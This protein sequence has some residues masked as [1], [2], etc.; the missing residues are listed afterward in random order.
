MEFEALVSAETKVY[1]TGKTNLEKHLKAKLAIHFGPRPGQ[2]SLLK[3]RDFELERLDS[4]LDAA[5]I[6]IPRLKQRGD[7]RSAFKRRPLI[8]SLG[9]LFE[10]HTKNLREQFGAEFDDPGDIPMF[11]ST[12]LN[13]KPEALKW[14]QSAGQVGLSIKNVLE[15]LTVYSERTGR[16]LHITETRIRRT[17]GTR[18][19][20]AG[21]GVLIIAEGLDH[22]GLGH[23]GVYAESRADIVQRIDA[24]TAA[25]L[26]PLAKAFLGTVIDTEKQSTNGVDPTSRIG[27]P[28]Y[29]GV[30]GSCKSRGGCR[31]NS[32]IACYRCESFEAWRDGPHPEV[33]KFLIEY[34][35]DLLRRGCE[36]LAQNLQL[37]IVACADLIRRIEG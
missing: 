9:A 11:P 30:Q 33:L 22:S 5:F 32:P 23:A 1:K 14:H 36:R 6:N 21:L 25:A 13:K 2:I 12:R 17:F 24:A 8:P 4:G 3:V 10:L 15:G 18:L 26:A 27:D 16:P 31:L 28:R 7:T 19:A 34:Q 35:D 37:T 20:A 29:N